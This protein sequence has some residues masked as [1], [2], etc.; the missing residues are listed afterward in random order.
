MVA[1]LMS[2]AMLI[3]PFQVVEAVLKQFELLHHSCP[4]LDY[5]LALASEALNVGV[6]Q[7]ID[8]VRDEKS[9]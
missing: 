9:R 5:F 6:L 3:E 2:S 4:L 7:V 1:L 8:R